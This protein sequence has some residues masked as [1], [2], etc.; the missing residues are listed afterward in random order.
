MSAGKL[1]HVQVYRNTG[2]A[3]NVSWS[4]VGTQTYDVGLTLVGETIPFTAALGLDWDIR[5]VLSYSSTPVSTATVTVKR[6]DYSVVT[7]GTPSAL[8]ATGDDTAILVQAV[9]KS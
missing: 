2:P 7:A 1:L 6:T 8:T 4:L 9:E 5:V 3:D